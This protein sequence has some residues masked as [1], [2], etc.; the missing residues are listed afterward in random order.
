[1]Q[2]KWKIN[3]WCKNEAGA[4][5]V[6]NAVMEG[7]WEEAKTHAALSLKTLLEGD[8]DGTPAYWTV[9]PDDL[10]FE[11]IPRHWTVCEVHDVLVSPYL[12]RDPL[13]QVAVRV[14]EGGQIRVVCEEGL[15]KAHDDVLKI[16]GAVV[17]KHLRDASKVT[18]E[19]VMTCRIEL[20]GALGRLAARGL[21]ARDTTA[22]KSIWVRAA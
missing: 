21:I 9:H 8:W 10:V 18:L 13:P 22:G 17:P 19:S 3:I 6:W 16:I 20:A 5:S 7:T 12:N 2:R 15:P 1:M 4:K 11:S 14:F